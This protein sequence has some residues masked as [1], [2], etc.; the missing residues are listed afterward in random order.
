VRV[1]VIF[2]GVA[3]ALGLLVVGLVA[4]PYVTG[5]GA[6]ARPASSPEPGPPTLLEP[7]PV[8]LTEPGFH[9][10]ALL[11]THTGAISGS[12]NFTDTSDPA[13]V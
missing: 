12:D 9:A 11:N 7:R 4:T 1:P 8:S 10:W 6:S 13:M 5:S 3:T 2:G